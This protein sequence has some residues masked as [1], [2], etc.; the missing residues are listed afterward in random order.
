VNKTLN[1]QCSKPVDELA[2]KQ[3]CKSIIDGLTMDMQKHSHKHNVWQWGLLTTC[4]SW[5]NK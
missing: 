4:S 2:R 1:I 5:A 3:Q